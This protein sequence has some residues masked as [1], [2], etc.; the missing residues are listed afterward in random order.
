M[1]NTYNIEAIREKL[2]I[3]IDPDNTEYTMDDF[4]KEFSGEGNMNVGM[5][6]FMKIQVPFSNDSDNPDPEYTTD[7][8]S[9]FDLRANLKEPIT[10]NFGERALIPTGLKFEIPSGFEIQVRPRSGLALK[11]GVTVLNTP[12]TVDADYRGEVGI[13]LINLGQEPF[14]VE[15][16]DRIAQGVLAHVTA[17]QVV[18][19]FKVDEVSEDTDRGAG[20]FGSTG[21][22]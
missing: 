2:M 6:D 8:A 11:K 14:T 9:G 22:K 16:G 20:G 5:P 18:R 17:K 1:S 3:A 13:I 15:H 12:G 4:N 7:G 10:L 19:L 21:T